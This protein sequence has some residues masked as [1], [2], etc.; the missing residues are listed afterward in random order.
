[1]VAASSRACAAPVPEVARCGFR[2]VSHEADA[3]VVRHPLANG[4][5]PEE[6]AVNKAVPRYVLDDGEQDWV[7]PFYVG[8]HLVGVTGVVP[9]LRDIGDVL[10]SRCC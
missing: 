7:P 2:R 8:E 10:R 9:I 5:F 1:M 4:V 3:A 6:L